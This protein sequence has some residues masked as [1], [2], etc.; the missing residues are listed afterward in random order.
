MPNLWWKPEGCL[1]FLVSSSVSEVVNPVI[2][3]VDAPQSAGL[4][5]L[6]VYGP[7]DQ[8]QE[9]VQA[10]EFVLNMNTWVTSQSVVEQVV[11]WGKR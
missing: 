1:N 5:S 3:S 9:K 11:D 4:Q 8:S 2:T 6:I 7:Q 10:P